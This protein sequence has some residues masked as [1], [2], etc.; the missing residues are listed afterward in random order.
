MIRKKGGTINAGEKV[1]YNNGVWQVKSGQTYW[2][3]NTPPVEGTLWTRL[4]DCGTPVTHSVTFNCG[5]G[6][7][8]CPSTVTQTSTSLAKPSDP[9]RTGY[10]FDGWSSQ[11]GG[12]AAITF[13]YTLQQTNTTLYAIWTA[14]STGCES[15]PRY[16]GEYK[17]YSA[18][19]SCATGYYN[20][21][22]IVK[23][24][25]KYYLCKTNGLHSVLPTML[26]SYWEETTCP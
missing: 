13:P 26:G 19:T 4:G 14:V 1:T 18:T 10:R 15:N 21:G 2:G 16:C 5:S 11:S 17:S 25:G 8:N 22:D 6:A 3:S 20:T 23:Y 12:T 7:S 24:S 9:S